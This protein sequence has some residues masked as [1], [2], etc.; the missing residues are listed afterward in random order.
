ML[1]GSIY[2]VDSIDHINSSL[3]LGIS[4]GLLIEGTELINFDEGESVTV[5]RFK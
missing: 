1:D 4:D 2:E 3:W 5:Y